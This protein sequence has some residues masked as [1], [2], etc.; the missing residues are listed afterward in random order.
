MNGDDG[1]GGGAHFD[2]GT[3]FAND[4]D[5]VFQSKYFGVC[6]H[7]DGW[8]GKL[9]VGGVH[10]YMQNPAGGP[11]ETEEEAHLA[12]EAAKVRLGWKPAAKAAKQS[13]MTGVRWHK[14]QEKWKV[15][16]ESALA[17][18][19]NGGKYKGLGSFDD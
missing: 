16:V 13:G 15:H 17:N 9:Y 14:G 3:E 11:F 6:R 18:R 5:H 4:P 7:H 12:V 19:L 1:G 2:R 8:Q 10:H